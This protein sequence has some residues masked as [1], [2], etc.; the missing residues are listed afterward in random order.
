MTSPPSLT[1]I[2]S[3]HVEHVSLRRG[4]TPVFH[5]LTLHLAERRIGLIGDNGAGKTSLLRLLCG[6]DVPESGSVR[7]DG[8]DMHCSGPERARLVGLM[9]QNPDEQIIHPV[10][11][12]EIALSFRTR[13]KARKEA[14]DAARQLLASHGRADWAGRAMGSLSQGQRQ[15]VCWLTLLAAGPR[16]LLLDE[17]FASLDLPSQDALANDI[18][19]APQQIIVSTHVLEH[20]R[21]FERVIWL[22]SGKVRADGPAGDICAAYEAEVTMRSALRRSASR[23]GAAHG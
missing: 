14:I 4:R 10:V 2:A 11:E 21:D 19:S 23:G 20:V 5:G 8:A 6:L 17:P 15:Q 1:P 7:M 13:G 12:E 18:A 3:T 9:F 16:V 22:E